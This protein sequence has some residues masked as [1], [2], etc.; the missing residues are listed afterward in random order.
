MFTNELIRDRPV[1]I[2]CLTSVG[3][4]VDDLFLGRGEVIGFR[5]TGGEWVITE[6]PKR[7]MLIQFLWMAIWYSRHSISVTKYLG[8]LDCWSLTSVI[9][10]SIERRNST[11]ACE[12][13]CCHLFRSLKSV[14]IWQQINP[15][16]LRR[17]KK[18]IVPRDLPFD[19]ICW[20]VRDRLA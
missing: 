15:Y 3:R 12:I 19:Y 18:K 7:H 14:H 20:C 16:R 17:L 10:F 13:E 5:M 9:G 6:S 1:I 4:G 8:W 2:F 11:A